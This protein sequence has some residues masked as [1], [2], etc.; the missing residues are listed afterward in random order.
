MLRDEIIQTATGRTLTITEARQK[1]ALHLAALVS[2][3]AAA[4]PGEGMSSVFA[5][6]IED[7]DKLCQLSILY[8]DD[9]DAFDAAVARMK[10]VKGSR[11]FLKLWLEAVQRQRRPLRLANAE[12]GIEGP[13]GLPAG[14]MVPEGYRMDSRGIFWIGDEADLQLTTKPL[15]VTGR[16]L[17]VDSGQCLVR[18]G[19]PGWGQSLRQQVVGR[20]MVAESGALITLASEGAPVHSANA[21]ELTRFIAATEV[22]NEDRLPVEFVTSRC[23]WVH[24]GFLLGRA[25]FPGPE[26]KKKTETAPPAEG[27]EEV[28]QRRS[29]V[30]LHVDGGEAQLADGLGIRGSWKGW[31]SAMV[32]IVHLPIP[33]LAV[34]ASVASVLL[35][36]LGIENGAAIDFSGETSRGKTTTLRAAASVWGKPAENAFLRTW[37]GTAVAIEHEAAFYGHLPLILDDTKHTEGDKDPGRKVRDTLY[38][39]TSGSGKAR[40]AKDG[41]MRTTLSWLSMLI[42]SGEQP[43]TAFTQDAGSRAR[44]L[45]IRG[46]PFDTEQNVR[47]VVNDL[48]DNYGHLGRRVIEYLLQPG[49]QLELQNE[50]EIARQAYSARLGAEGGVGNRL[51]TTV[52]LLDIARDLCGHVGAPELTC[53][54]L[55]LAVEAAKESSQEADRPAAALR[56]LYEM[57]VANSTHFYG[58]HQVTKV[59]EGYEAIEPT[60]AGG[61]WGKWSRD[62]T[63][64]SISF[65]PSRAKAVL[66]GA[67]FDIEGTIERWN[68]RGWLTRGE[69]K[70]REKKVWLDGKAVRCLV[71]GRKVLVDVVGLE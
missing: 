8:S 63:W 45:C 54:P 1:G 17:D 12:D 42:S 35:D 44:C 53:D 58:R 48:G 55:E 11:D 3:V 32:R 29:G 26:P 6:I 39:H 71:I 33:W 68:E 40:G 24:G 59:A 56:L 36:Y 46:S 31:C 34:Y 38:A 51:A 13:D 2:A 28:V 30:E 25:W 52:A 7:P 14:L 15:W 70:N 65:L 47:L 23:G 50:F 57:A 49:N 64:D 5:S 22:Q 41:G 60:S 18:L 66:E 37:K 62:E 4:E 10:G 69:G 20:Q 19:W 9:R 61:W 43:A 67:R 21:R 16:L 27:A